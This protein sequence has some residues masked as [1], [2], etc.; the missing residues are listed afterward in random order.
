MTYLYLRAVILVG[1]PR[2]SGDP[3]LLFNRSFIDKQVMLLGMHNMMMKIQQT[4]GQETYSFLVI[5]VTF[6]FQLSHFFLGLELT[7]E[8]LLFCLG[9][10]SGG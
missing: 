3:Y 7:L 8:Y 2:A 9:V 6:S 4:C 5:C 1:H 10:T